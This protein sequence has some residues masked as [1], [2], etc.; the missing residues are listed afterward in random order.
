MTLTCGEVK[1]VVGDADE[2]L[3]AVWS[4]IC[5][6][7]IDP[8]S[9]LSR[10]DKLSVVL[11]C[12]LDNVGLITTLGGPLITDLEDEVICDRQVSTLGGCLSEMDDNPGGGGLGIGGRGPV[13]G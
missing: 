8:V 12:L 2:L 4:I 5:Q 11:I 9:S 13:G 6:L 3:S 7:A 10:S 1:G